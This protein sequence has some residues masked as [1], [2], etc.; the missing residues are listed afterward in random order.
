MVVCDPEKFDLYEQ[1]GVKEYWVV[2][3]VGRW[4]Q[5]YC[6]APE[7]AYA[8]EI[9]WEETGTLESVV[10]PGFSLVIQELW[11]TTGPK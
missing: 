6:L 7:G 1:S 10:L 5:Q 3:P 11:A 4:V 2:E 9:T 8:P